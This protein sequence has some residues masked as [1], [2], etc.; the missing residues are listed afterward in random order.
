MN[1]ASTQE[2]RAKARKMMR[3]GILSAFAGGMG[4]AVFLLQILF[5]GLSSSEEVNAAINGTCLILISYA[6]AVIAL[7]LFKR[8]WL[9]GLNPIMFYVLVPGAIL[10]L[11]I[12][13]F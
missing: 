8:N 2:D 5:S 6:G 10:R 1:Y 9:L 11:W 4:L 12:G 3:A 7:Y 13:H